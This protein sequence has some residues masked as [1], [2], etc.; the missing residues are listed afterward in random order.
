MSV[1]VTSQCRSGCNIPEAACCGLEL[2]IRKLDES[3]FEDNKDICSLYAPCSLL[4][5]S[6]SPLDTQ[7]VDDEI[8]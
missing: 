8:E 4:Q 2:L 6:G 5:F 3:C 7:G 1:N